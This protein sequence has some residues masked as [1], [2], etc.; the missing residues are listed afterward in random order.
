MRTLTATDSNNVTKTFRGTFERFDLF[1]L[2]ETDDIIIPTNASTIET[3]LLLAKGPL[4]RYDASKPTCHVMNS[5]PC[6]L[7]DHIETITELS[8]YYEILSKLN[9]KQLYYTI[10]LADFLKWEAMA[11]YAMAYVKS[12]MRKLDTKLDQLEY[13]NPFGYSITNTGTVS[14]RPPVE[15]VW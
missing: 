10:M 7:V 8:Y 15:W 13:L 12:E 5:V 1:R 14:N 4:L 2:Y 6:P 9:G 3:L 11:V